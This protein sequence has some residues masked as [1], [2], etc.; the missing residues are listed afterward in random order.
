M[1]K[2]LSTLIIM[3]TIALIPL[4]AAWQLVENFE[5]GNLDAWEIHL[6]QP[7]SSY[8]WMI[9]PDTVDS[10]NNVA[11]VSP[12]LNPDNRVCPQ[13][14]LP[15]TAGDGETLT[16]YFRIMSFGPNKDVN[17]G[18]T[19]TPQELIAQS[20]GEFEAQLY[21]KNAGT[22]IGVR[23][24]SVVQDWDLTYSHNVWYEYWIVMRNNVGVEADT[25]D[26]YMRGGSE[27]P[28]QQL[29]A[30]AANFRNGTITGLTKFMLIA[31]YGSE[32]SPLGA[33]PVAFDDIHVAAGQVLSTPGEASNTWAGYEE[34]ASGW[35][36]AAGL[37]GMVYPVGDWVYVLSL[38]KFIYLPE[39]HVTAAGAWTYIIK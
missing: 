4:S 24:G 33:D 36:D 5:S 13:I 7:E 23:N 25:F 31:Y 19:D 21:I 6:A 35:Y 20:W 38:G 17:F 34:L 14:N 27:F 2:L 39:S 1:K 9:G 30:Q 26:V 16:L 22:G 37:L 28:Q 32:A 18:V 11:Y 29:V 15:I 3:P 12:G 8:T 10:T